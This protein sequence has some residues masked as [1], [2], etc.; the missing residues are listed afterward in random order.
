MQDA[1]HR[2]SGARLHRGKMVWSGTRAR[3]HRVAW[4]MMRRLRRVVAVIISM[5]LFIGSSHVL[6]AALILQSP[7]LLEAANL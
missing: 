3:A 6:G 1:L 7:L 2:P 4:R 5:A